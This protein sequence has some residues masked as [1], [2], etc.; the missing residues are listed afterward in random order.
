MYLDALVLL[1]VKFHRLILRALQTF[2][3]HIGATLHLPTTDKRKTH[4]P[5]PL[6]APGANLQGGTS[7]SVL[8]DPFAGLPFRNL[9]EKLGAHMA[10]AVEQMRADKRKARAASTSNAAAAMELPPVPHLLPFTRW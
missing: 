4:H 1:T 5:E 8:S 9:A 3:L 7:Q 2:D 6:P 10:P